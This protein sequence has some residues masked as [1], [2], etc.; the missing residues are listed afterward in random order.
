MELSVSDIGKIKAHM[1]VAPAN[2]PSAE[3][4]WKALKVRGTTELVA[5]RNRSIQPQK[6]FEASALSLQTLAQTVAKLEAAFAT[7]ADLLQNRK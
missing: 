5:L 6:E 3:S 4:A 7:I 2:T 1:V